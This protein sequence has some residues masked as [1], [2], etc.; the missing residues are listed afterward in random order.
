MPHMLGWF[1]MKPETSI[2]DA[3][4]LL[5]RAAGFDAGFALVTS[6]HIVRMNGYGEEILGAIKQWEKARMGGAFNENQKAL[7]KSVSNEFHLEEVGDTSWNLYR[8]YPGK[9]THEKIIRQPGEPVHSKFTFQNKGEKQAM[10]FILTAKGAE[11][12]HI[13]FEINNH[14]QLDIPV[15]LQPGESLKYNGGDEMTLYD[16][17]WQGIK[18]VKVDRDQLMIEPGDHSLIFDCQFGSGENAEVKVELRIAGQPELISM[19]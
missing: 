4:W 9:F 17:T 16:E 19:N 2:E 3:E 8:I 1:S 11:A 7:M 10:A 6:P 18:V 15:S 14:K 12:A 13:T 5:A